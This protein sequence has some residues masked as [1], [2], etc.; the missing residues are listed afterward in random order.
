[1]RKGKKR[2]KSTSEIGCYRTPPTGGLVPNPGMFPDPENRR[3]FG[4]R[5][6]PNSLSHTSLGSEPTLVKLPWPLSFH[7]RC[8]EPCTNQEDP[9]PQAPPPHGAPCAEPPRSRESLKAEN[10]ADVSASPLP[11]K[12][13]PQP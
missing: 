8:R 13:S 9:R 6:T 7:V 4:V 2:E 3:L 11:P 5:R 10:G 1:M 12:E